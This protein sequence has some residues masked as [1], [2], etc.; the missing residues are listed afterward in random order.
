[1]NKVQSKQSVQSVQSMTM[2]AIQRASLISNFKV[3]SA[4]AR[5]SQAGKAQV[6]LTLSGTLAARVQAVRASGGARFLVGV[7]H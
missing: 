6:L 7:A 4:A 2:N 1:M 5:Q 3:H